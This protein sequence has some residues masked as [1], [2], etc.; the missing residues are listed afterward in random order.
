ML[1]DIILLSLPSDVVVGYHRLGATSKTS[2]MLRIG[3]QDEDAES[4]SP[5]N[6]EKDTVERE[7]QVI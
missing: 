3:E 2:F 4:L 5:P 6:C 1:T 7:L